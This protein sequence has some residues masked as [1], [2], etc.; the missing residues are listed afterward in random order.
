LRRDGYQQTSPED[1]QY[2]CIAWAAGDVDRWWWPHEDYWPPGAPEDVNLAAFIAA[3]RT[4]GYEPCDTGRLEMAWE[5]VVIYCLAGAP[6]HAAR[7]LDDGTWTS[8][9]GTFWDITHGRPEGVEGPKYGEA[10][11]F[12]RRA[13]PA[14]RA[15]KRF[16][17]ISRRWLSS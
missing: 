7:Q 5:K 13:L 14:A 16:R 10:Q 11:Q 1:D 17:Q 3:Y 2:N 15:A 4:R 9:L 12:L 6:T 8:K